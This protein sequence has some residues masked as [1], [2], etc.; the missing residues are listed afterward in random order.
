MP[1][2]EFI[3]S[4]RKVEVSSGSTLLEASVAA[5]VMVESPCSGA[6]V[7]GKCKVWLPHESRRL[8]RTDDSLL[9]SAE[10]ALGFVLACHAIAIADVK[11]TIPEKDDGK[12]KI[13]H[14]GKSV[15]LPFIPA[16]SKRYDADNNHTVV[17]NFEGREIT[18]ETGD[19]TAFN[20]ALAIDIGTTTLVVS[21]IDLR[22]GKE[23]ASKSALNPQAR[24]AGDVL[25][26]IKMGSEPEG[27]A[28]LYGELAAEIDRLTGELAAET[29]IS[30]QFI[31]EA[32]Y[33]GN[34][35]MLH[36][37]ASVNPYSLGKLPFTPALTTPSDLPA[38]GLGLNL[39]RKAS[40]YLPPVVSGF[41]GADITAGILATGLDKLPG[42]TLFIDI[43]TNGEMVLNR[44]GKMLATS[45]AAG[46]AFEGM[47]ISCGMRA[48][49]GA[50][51][52]FKVGDSGI[53]LRTIGNEQS[54]GL[55]GSGLID[56]VAELVAA[57]AID[58]NGKLARPGKADNVHPLIVP[59]LAEVE[60]KPAFKVADNVF[61]LQ[62]DIR[63]VQLAKG[64]VRVGVD[65]LLRN[66]GI[67]P[68]QVD[69]VL[70]A[71]SFGYH[72]RTESL[73]RLGLLPES[74]ADKVEF[75]GNTSLAGA[76][77]LLTC[78]E[79]RERL[80]Q[81]ACEVTTVNLAETADFQ[82][83]FVNAMSF[84]KI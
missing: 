12:M 30:R 55:C 70:V 32:V 47:N 78:A 31:Y 11:V 69:L 80:Q 68:E 43:G 6:G 51:E 27:L 65:L 29:G 72:L 8:V 84:P 15:E 19:T 41:V 74:F 34:T 54:S 48:L 28:L 9:P 45:T 66:A 10:I 57:G 61:L 35:C 3:P 63:Q 76:K 50:V 53:M 25:S 40:V 14:A 16:F 33:A 75:V 73:I 77:L 7:C 49:S 36:L 4:G 79:A 24:R 18:A 22:T 37:A 1:V 60:G 38:S 23:L 58:R 62:K 13:L 42:S 52:F 26:R 2:I 21:L 59:H 71:G 46:P 5:G 20:T 67:A 64:A 56:V 44:D 81:A 82:Q 17:S 83:V 39:N